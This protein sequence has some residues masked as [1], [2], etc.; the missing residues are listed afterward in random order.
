MIQFEHGRAQNGMNQ[1]DSHET[2][3]ENRQQK[4][5]F[6]FCNVFSIRDPDLPGRRVNLK[7]EE[8]PIEEELKSP[9]IPTILVQRQN[10][11]F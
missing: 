1:S 11:T 7:R 3:P 9:E 4:D 10:F 5:K 6:P 8:I 2:P